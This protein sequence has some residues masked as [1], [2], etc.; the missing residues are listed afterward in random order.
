[1]ERLTVGRKQQLADLI[2]RNV[3]LAMLAE[4]VV[5][6]G[7]VANFDEMR[8]AA[9]PDPRENLKAIA[10]AV[11]DAYENA[12]LL[13]GLIQDLYRRGWADS[14][15]AQAMSEF[16]PLKGAGQQQAAFALRANFLQSPRLSK[17]LNDCEPKLCVI[18]ARAD[19]GG[20][21]R[22][23]NGTGF[24]VGPD[25]VLTARHVL[26]YHISEDGLQIS[27]S[28]GPLYAFF[29][30]L[31]G[32]P[33]INV[34]DI[35][36]QLRERTRVVEFAT[37]WLVTA[38]GDIPG[39]AFY[40]PT[41]AQI[42]ELE[43][44]LDYALVR[45]IEP[46]GSY[47]RYVY[48]GTRRGW[49]D[50]SSFPD[51]V[52]RKDDRIIIPQ[53][54]SGQPQRIDFGRFNRLDASRTRLQYNAETA[55]GTSGAP[56]F[57][58]DC[59]LVGVHNAAY[60]PHDIAIF[61]QAVHFSKI[62]SE[63]REKYPASADASVAPIWSV[64]PD[65][66]KPRVIVGRSA[67]MKW[68]GEA[69]TELPGSR[70]QRVHA[71]EGARR[72]GKT[73]SIEILKAALRG[74]S[75]RIVEFGTDLEK[76]PTTAADFASA[77]VTQIGIPLDGVP[78]MPARPSNEQSEGQAGDKLNVWLSGTGRK[79]SIPGWFNDVLF[80]AREW[81]GNL[82]AEARV[83]IQNPVPGTPPDPHDVKI[84]GAAQD[85]MEKRS[86][87]QRIWI[88]IDNVGAQNVDPLREIMTALVGFRPEES[89]VLDELRRIRWLFLGHKPAFIGT[90][91]TE[92]LDS[93][94]ILATSEAVKECIRNFAASYNS[95]PQ[96]QMLGYAAIDVEDAVSEEPLM[97]DYN[98]PLKRLEALQSAI[99][100]LQSKF[101]R[102]FRSVR[103]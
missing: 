43:K 10:L 90:I 88:V 7:V 97:S 17:F 89:T 103:A 81:E 92:T 93:N 14:G 67:L 42:E 9:P 65:S 102:L 51:R 45:L 62:M 86:R 18:T 54:P 72:S 8:K 78:A 36:P 80:S 34:D 20:R 77:V 47:S 73:F 39:E 55:G 25:L 33:I 50:L 79:D 41:P 2:A 63:L 70:S 100:S 35:T 69:M 76:I 31:Y 53:H 49:Y 32:D 85:I 12:G 84:A 94:Q 96:D 101:G 6:Q 23:L 58:Q 5:S 98:N 27:P 44:K 28:P 61:N 21:A 30:H 87:W 83:R 59:E 1:L 82:S 22:Y 46:I 13:L 95:T 48:G 29:D 75:D 99:G 91:S 15:F 38:C 52:P 68:I 26:R 19:V 60:Q 16:L 40:E 3:P 4:V 37:D 56:C 24:L 74:T 11:I 57:N 71:V 66:H 64:S